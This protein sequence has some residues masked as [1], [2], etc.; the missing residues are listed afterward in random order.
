MIRQVDNRALWRQRLTAG[1]VAVSVVGLC[2]VALY[3]I[4]SRIVPW[5]PPWGQA[6]AAVIGA[7]LFL[8][9]PFTAARL[10]RRSAADRQEKDG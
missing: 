4:G 7:L 3:L 1:L 8:L 9:S 10:I 6:L 2:V 5:L